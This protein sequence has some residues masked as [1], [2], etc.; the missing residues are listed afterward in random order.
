MGTCLIEGETVRDFY[1][2]PPECRTLCIK[3]QVGTIFAALLEKSE[4]S[5]ARRWQKNQINKLLQEQAGFVKILWKCIYLKA[6]FLQMSFLH[7][8]NT[9]P[10]NMRITER[11]IRKRISGKEVEGI[12]C[13]TT[14]QWDCLII[15]I[16]TY[17]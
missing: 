4:D 6:C 15:T 7:W 5:S 14:L 16:V 3:K 9:R 17:C 13:G 8:E 1:L 12:S 2:P 11:S 10:W